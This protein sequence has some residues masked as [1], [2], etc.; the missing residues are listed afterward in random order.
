MAGKM[1]YGTQIEWARIIGLGN[2]T[3]KSRAL[4]VIGPLPGDCILP[5]LIGALRCSMYNA[6]RCWYQV[7]FEHSSEQNAW[8]YFLTTLPIAC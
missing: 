4:Y 1:C 3:L 7:S 2:C 8:E 5:F 6:V